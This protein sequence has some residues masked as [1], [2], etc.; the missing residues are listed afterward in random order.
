MPYWPQNM[1]NGWRV[2][3]YYF[4][5][6]WLVAY[7]VKSQCLLPCSCWCLNL[8][9]SKFMKKENGEIVPIAR[10]RYLFCWTLDGHTWYLAIMIRYRVSRRR[11]SISSS[12]GKRKPCGF[13]YS[14]LFSHTIWIERKCHVIC[15]VIILQSHATIGIR[16]TR[17][18]P[19]N[20][21]R[22][23]KLQRRCVLGCIWRPFY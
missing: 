22:D 17:T 1:T 15:D 14:N 23:G 6:H 8:W 18:L 3:R 7:S 2:S 5:L 20:L 16:T 13:H 11:F 9:T 4:S 21:N 19:S 10:M 12:R